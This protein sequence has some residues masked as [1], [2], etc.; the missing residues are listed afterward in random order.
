MFYC[1]ECRVKNKWIPS[2]LKSVGPCELCKK[3]GDCNDLKSSKIIE[4]DHCYECR[5]E[6]NNCECHIPD[7][8][9]HKGLWNLINFILKK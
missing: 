1:N 3:V 4:T 7:K 8:E 9:K 6:W 2:V 5:Q